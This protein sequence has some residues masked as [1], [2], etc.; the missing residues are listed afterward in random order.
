MAVTDSFLCH[1]IVCAVFS[2]RLSWV[3]SRWAIG[4]SCG[5]GAALCRGREGEMLLG[6]I[7]QTAQG[8]L[9]RAKVFTICYET[10]ASSRSINIVWE[11]LFTLRLS[12]ASKVTTSVLHL[13]LIKM[14]WALKNNGLL[15]TDTICT[16]RLGGIS[17]MQ[18]SSF[19]L[20][21]FYIFF[22]LD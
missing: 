19:P 9:K 16:L 15:L 8:C 1:A 21:H 20:L 2:V 17:S 3:Q 11:T 18:A 5:G 10:M 13:L 12:A 7:G 14:L 6:L 22:R 4:G